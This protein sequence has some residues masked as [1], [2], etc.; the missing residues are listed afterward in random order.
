MIRL[1]ESFER[2]FLAQVP[3]LRLIQICDIQVRD[4]NR[5]AHVDCDTCELLW[6]NLQCVLS[7]F[8]ECNTLLV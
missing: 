5:S 6:A 3:V 4:S 8:K 2:W 1:G 7:V